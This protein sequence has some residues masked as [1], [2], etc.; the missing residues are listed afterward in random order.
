V[1]AAGADGT[2]VHRDAAGWT[3]ATPISSARIV[4][5]WAAATNDV[6]AVG[7]SA[8]STPAAFHFSGAV[9][10][11]QTLPPANDLRALWGAA[12][13]DVW[14]VGHDSNVL[15]W[16]GSSFGAVQATPMQDYDAVAG[17]GSDVYIVG[18]SGRILHNLEPEESGTED[19]L[20]H[21]WASPT[22]QDVFAVG[23]FGLVLH[24]GSD[25]MWTRQPAETDQPLFA[26]WGS[27]RGDLYAAGR[28]GV[29]LHNTGT[30]V[31]CGSDADC[32]PICQSGSLTP[33][34]CVLGACVNGSSV[35]CE[36]HLTCFDVNRCRSRCDT[37]N[38]C[39]DGYFC[40]PDGECRPQKP[41]GSACDDALGA[42]CLEAGCRVCA[43]GLFCT[44]HICC[45]TAPAQCGGCMH[46]VAPSGTCVPQPYGTANA[47][48]EVASGGCNMPVCNGQGGCGNSGDACG[49]MCV[50]NGNSTG[51]ETTHTCA[52]G[53]CTADP[54]F[55][56]PSPGCGGA[57]D[58]T[59]GLSPC[60]TDASCTTGQYCD[61]HHYCAPKKAN[62]QPCN[63]SSAAH[64]PAPP[65]NTECASGM[66]VD[67]FCCDKPCGSTCMACDLPG[68][69]GTCSTVTSGGP[70]GARTAC[71]G[72]GACTALCDGQSP[73][74]C[75]D[76]TSECAAQAC[77]SANNYTLKLA[78][79]CTS[80]ACPAQTTM[81]CQPYACVHAACRASCST[82][83]DCAS[84]TP[85]CDLATGSCR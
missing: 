36:A 29:L 56:C 20:F 5:L 39:A 51:T 54:T 62:G 15:R 85:T 44:D 24:R 9:W 33:R 42:E 31:E 66:C 71:G 84:T 70:H 40:G 76:V 2:F 80:G 77:D 26:V 69:L 25:G 23:D 7:R 13:N 48:C 67:G 79:S 11:T 50:D 35:V 8:V 59:G 82:D 52:N 65:C 55:L 47:A 68:M 37:D 43:T 73:S 60:S 19:D 10:Q 61:G 18:R 1:W 30:A 16:T 27:A 38:N 72:S 57:T 28:G 32:P 21:V 3:V 17:A 14:L 45:D 46:C 41:Q 63:T 4:G 12:S 34:T 81:S 74:A 6:W 49:N 58:C 83:A 64:C 53:V 22:G 75:S 78:A